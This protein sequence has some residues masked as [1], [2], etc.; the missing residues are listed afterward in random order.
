MLR[1]KLKNIKKYLASY[2]DENT[3]DCESILPAL[4]LLYNTSFHSTI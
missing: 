3:F 4:M 1:S 2:M